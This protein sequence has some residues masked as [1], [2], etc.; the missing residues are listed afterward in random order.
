MGVNSA[1]RVSAGSLIKN[2]TLGLVR[3]LIHET[4]VRYCV[5]ITKSGIEMLSV[6]LVDADYV[7][8]ID[9]EV[10][11]FVI[12]VKAPVAGYFDLANNWNMFETVGTVVCLDSGYFMKFGVLISGGVVEETLRDVIVEFNNQ[13]LKSVSKVQQ[14]HR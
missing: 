2:V 6:V 1:M 9:G 4:N 11:T 3:N 7:V 8:G 13:A 5:N 10:L 14:A 12:Q